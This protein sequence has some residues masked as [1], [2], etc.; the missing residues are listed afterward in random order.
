MTYEKTLRNLRRVLG[1]VK[2]PAE[3]DRYAESLLKLRDEV[4]EEVL[5]RLNLSDDKKAYAREVLSEFYTSLISGGVENFWKEEYEGSYESVRRDIS[6]ELFIFIASKF[7][8]VL[9]RKVLDTVDKEEAK[10]L[11]PYLLSTVVS[12]LA[13]IVSARQDMEYDFLGITSELMDRIRKLGAN[14]G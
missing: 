9:T 10:V 3:L 2:R 12:G 5:S 8:A 6:A 1:D 11:L 13:F 4:V 14:R 7:V